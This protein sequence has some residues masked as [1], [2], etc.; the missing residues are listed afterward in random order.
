[1]NNTEQKTSITQLNKLSSFLELEDNWDG[2]GAKKPDISA[3]QS[4]I[5]F[6]NFMV[7]STDM[8]LYFTCPTGGG[9]VILE[10]A[11]PN[12]K[13]FTDPYQ[14]IRFRVTE[15]GVYFSSFK[16]MQN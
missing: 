6:A 2:Y 16:Q 11:P 10:F 13:Q 7:G 8:V 14:H 1:M 3:I 9:G 12:S 4:A 5:I 15:N